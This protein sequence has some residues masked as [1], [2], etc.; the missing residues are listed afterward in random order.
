M[1]FRSYDQTTGNYKGDAV[2]HEIRNSTISDSAQRCIVV[3]GTNGVK[4][5]NN[6]CHN[7]TGHAMFL[8]DAVERRN[9]FDGNLVLG[10]KRPAAANLMALHEGDL[11]DAG[12]SGF[13]ITN[14]DNI[15]RNNVVGDS[16]GNAYWNSFPTSGVGRSEER[17]VGKEC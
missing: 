3:H 11:G 16:I 12:S 15:I 13:W 7:I 9:V 8:E 17:R 2:G 4:V 6:I 5:V 10:V 1:L 14:P